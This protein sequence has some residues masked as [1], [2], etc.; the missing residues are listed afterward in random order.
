MGVG[1]RVQELDKPTVESR[2][3]EGKRYGFMS[4]L[5]AEC[6]FVALPLSPELGNGEE[7]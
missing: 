6:S 4:F 2:N 1:G 7:D 5:G 3:G